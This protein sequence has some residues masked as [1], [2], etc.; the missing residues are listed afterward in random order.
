MPLKRKIVHLAFGL[1]LQMRNHFIK[2][3]N[4]KKSDL[5]IHL[6]FLTLL[7]LLCRAKFKKNLFYCF[8]LAQIIFF[9]VSCSA[10]YKLTIV[11][12]VKCNIKFYFSVVLFSLNKL[13]KH[14][15][16]SFNFSPLYIFF[17]TAVNVLKLL[18]AFTKFIY[19][20]WCGF[21]SVYPPWDLMN[22]LGFVGL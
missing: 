21:L 22:F 16:N 11:C 15:K 8:E 7:I 19:T 3:E 2:I 9:N 5:S 20:F 13:L 18:F 4:K 6:L 12:D 1:E 17:L 10:T 14:F